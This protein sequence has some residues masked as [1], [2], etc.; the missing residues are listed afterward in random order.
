MSFTLTMSGVIVGRT[1]LESRDA[2]RKVAL[3]TFRPGLGYE[4]AQP[5][6]DLYEAAG[7]DPAGLDRYRRARDALQLELTDAGGSQVRFRDLHIRRAKHTAPG[8]AEYV[9]EVSS[10]DARIWAAS[11]T[12]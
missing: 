5:V 10:D 4:L 11:P 6:F 9:I 12:S 7:T 8:G 3:G 2:D 1:D